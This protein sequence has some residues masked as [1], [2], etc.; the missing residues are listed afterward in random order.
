MTDE[1]VSFRVGVNVL[2]I[3][4]GKL[5]LGLRKNVYGDGMW[6]LPGGHLENKEAM[7]AAAAR[8]LVEE[9]GLSAKDFVFTNLLNDFQR[10]R[11]Y[12]QVGFVASG[13]E[14]EPELKE[15]DRC[16]EWGWFDLSSLPENI[17]WGHAKQIALYKADK[18]FDDD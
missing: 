6:G 3:R 9:T 16:S 7:K 13:V 18:R 17:F 10:E 5:L 11:H 12:L 1:Y 14:G 2:V 4:D 15:P 8:E